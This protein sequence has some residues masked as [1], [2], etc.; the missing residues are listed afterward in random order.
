[1]T[2]K[3]E[4]CNKLFRIS[5]AY[6]LSLN[7]SRLT[8]QKPTDEVMMTSLISKPKQS[9]ELLKHILGWEELPVVIQSLDVGVLTKLIRYVGLEDSAEIVSLA[10]TEQLKG[11]LEEDLWHSDKPGLDETFDAERFGLWLEIMMENGSDFAVRKVR[12]LDEDL[13]TLGFCR[14]VWVVDLHNLSMWLNDNRQ[15]RNGHALEEI[16]D[17]ALHQAFGHY[18]AVSKDESSWDSVCALMAAL[19]ELDYDML[20]RLLDR[21]S[22]ISGECMEGNGD[23]YH[24]LTADETLEEDVSS[25]R[26]ERRENK[27]FVTPMSATVFLNQA[28]STPLP[29]II[30]AETID[31]VSRAY[32]R[33]ME[34]E[35]APDLRSRK[36]ERPSE[37]SAS[38]AGNPKVLRLIQTLQKAVAPQAFQ[39]KMLAYD[40][41]APWDHPLPLAGAM[42][43]INRTDPDLFSWRMKEI[44]Y[45]SNTLISGCAYKGRTFQPKEAAEAAF[46]VCNLGGEYLLESH[47]E[48]KGDLSVDPWTAILKVHHFV[49]LFQVGWKILFYGVVTHTAKM[50]LEFFRHQK[51]EMPNSAQAYEIAKK[52]SLLRFCISSGRPWEFKDQMDDMQPYLDDETAVAIGDLLRA[53]PTL[54][55]V[56]C[57]KEEHPLFPFIWSQVHIGTISRFLTDVL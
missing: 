10:T 33:A 50:L 52:I 48:P 4:L 23:L 2:Q 6:R 34:T 47:T 51:N 19:N 27:G 35:T 22:W 46:S 32:F 41:A 42:G 21:C 29:E 37:K 8:G 1:L 12:A 45:L 30:A 7:V 13:L 25:E 24:V 38:E 54:S 9:G 20:I 49:K 26:K 39:Q 56:I 57:R 53:Y 5:T 15:P 43:L 40:G 11:I 55:E 14:L 31:P 16:L 3:E 18:V 17:G 44:S 36:V 28:R